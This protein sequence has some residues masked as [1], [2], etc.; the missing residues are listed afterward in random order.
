MRITNKDMIAYF[1]ETG[2]HRD[3]GPAVI[4]ISGTVLYYHHGSMVSNGIRCINPNGS[5]HWME[6][7]QY[8]VMRPNGEIFSRSIE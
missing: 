6:N 1:G 3:V 4:E 8:C 2:V 5:I 7:N